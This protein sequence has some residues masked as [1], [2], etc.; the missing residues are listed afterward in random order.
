M[1]KLGLLAVLLFVMLFS[2]CQAPNAAQK[3]DSTDSHFEDVTAWNGS[4]TGTTYENATDEILFTLEAMEAEE[5]TVSMTVKFVDLQK[6]PYSEIEELS[7][8]KYTVLDQSGA[9]VMEGRADYRAVDR[10]RG[11]TVFEVPLTGLEKGDYRIK[12]EALEGKK[13]AEQPILIS[14]TWECGFSCS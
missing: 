12:I 7:I 13:K 2:A 5:A 11:E 1:K 8:P 3:P 4:V 9:A 10:E 14:G 6:L